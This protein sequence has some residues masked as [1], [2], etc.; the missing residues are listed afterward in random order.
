MWKDWKGQDINPNDMV[1]LDLGDGPH[2]PCVVTVPRGLPPD[3]DQIPLIDVTNG[4]DYY[5]RPSS[6]ECSGVAPWAL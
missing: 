3:P 4:K 6:V 5:A 2:R 1:W